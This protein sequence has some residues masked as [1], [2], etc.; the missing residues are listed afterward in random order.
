[1]QQIKEARRR[2]DISIIFPL[3]TVQ[4]LII[5]PIKIPLLT[6]QLEIRFVK[7]GLSARR[8][9]PK[10]RYQHIR[11]DVLPRR[12][13]LVRDGEVPLADQDDVHQHIAPGGE[14]R[15][16]ESAGAAVGGGV[17]FR[18]RVRVQR[19]DVDDEVGC[20]GDVAHRR[21]DKGAVRFDDGAGDHAATDELAADVCIV[22]QGPEVGGEVFEEGGRGCV[23]CRVADGLGVQIVCERRDQSFNFG[24]RDIW[25]V[26][27]GNRDELV[28][29]EVSDLN[30]G[31]DKGGKARTQSSPNKRPPRCSWK[32]LACL[33]LRLARLDELWRSA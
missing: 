22:G 28:D 17:R 29:D 30:P 7:I 19:D 25:G 31:V 16:G 6:L 3:H 33:R 24:G 1:M 2:R 18:V 13:L 26:E 8:D 4:P 5:A 32:E 9:V 14:N 12:H 10:L 23:I 21:G 27:G 20:A 11:H 15:V